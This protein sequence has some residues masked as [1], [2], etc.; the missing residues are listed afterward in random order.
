VSD[1]ISRAKPGQVRRTAV[2]FVK[3]GE[4]GRRPPKP[5]ARSGLDGADDWSL[6]CD[7]KGEGRYPSAITDSGLR[8]D[9]VLTSQKARRM[10]IVEL[11][12]PFET[13][14]AENHEYK[15]AKYEELCKEVR[16]AGFKVD[17]FAVEVGARGFLGKSM[18]SFIAWLG[19][20]ARARKSLSGKVCKAAESASRWIWLQRNNGESTCGRE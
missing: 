13:R 14:I 8:P 12:V 4:K 2:A 20:P 18:R 11:T 7:L 1:A 6:A 15:V 5:R 17:F 19:G 16:K 9:L 10:V 3:E